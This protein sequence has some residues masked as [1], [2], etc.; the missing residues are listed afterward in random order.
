MQLHR[1][2]I[3]VGEVAPYLGI[4]RQAAD[5]LRKSGKYPTALDDRGRPQLLRIPF[6]AAHR[7]AWRA[8]HAPSEPQGAQAQPRPAS[9]EPAPGQVMLDVR[10]GRAAFASVLHQAMTRDPYE[11]IGVLWNEFQH[12]NL[13]RYWVCV[14]PAT[15]HVPPDRRIDPRQFEKDHERV[16]HRVW[17]ALYASW[18]AG[19]KDEQL[20]FW[21]ALTVEM[22]ECLK[23]A[24][25]RANS[26]GE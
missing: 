11:V 12:G 21:N 3:G 24:K 2:F 4:S 16:S 15:G 18:I 7:Q 22:R 1:K 25:V 14:D 13:G 19:S 6:L 5:K 17:D 26:K 8:A 10:L 20:A 23:A 9:Q